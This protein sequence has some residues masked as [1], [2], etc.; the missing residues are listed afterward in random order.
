M[1]RIYT[2]IIAAWLLAAAM[3]ALASPNSPE[4]DLLSE[5][6][7]LDQRIFEAAFLTCDEDAL[8][9]LL[10]PDLEF[11]HD[12]YGMIA[13]DLEAFLVGTLSDCTS[14]RAGEL[15][16]IERRLVPDSMEVRRVGDWGALQTGQHTFHGRDEQDQDVLLERGTFMHVWE[17]S[18]MGWRIKRVISYDHVSE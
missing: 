7:P 8:R 12:L 9:A 14:R 2:W 1:N 3:P 11:Y 13:G 17:R 5:I 15:P 6:E 16:Y 18:D 10:S 4:S